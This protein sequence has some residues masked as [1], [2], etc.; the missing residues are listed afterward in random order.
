MKAEVEQLRVQ[1]QEP[2]EIIFA[3]V[4]LRR[5]KY[6]IFFAAAS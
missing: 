5:P 6:V 3:D 1:V 2:R 4:L